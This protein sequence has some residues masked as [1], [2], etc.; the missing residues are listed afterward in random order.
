[1]TYPSLTPSDIA[2]MRELL[3]TSAPAPFVPLRSDTPNGKNADFNFYLVNGDGRKT[4]AIWGRKGEK[5]ATAE[6]LMMLR[7]FAPELI[8]A[9]AIM[10]GADKDGDYVDPAGHRFIATGAGAKCERCGEP[11]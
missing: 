5:E 11:S 8:N 3:A 9:A 1:M 2:R 7:N 6:L 4:A 10:W